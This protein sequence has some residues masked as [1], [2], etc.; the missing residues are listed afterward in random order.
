LNE[1][2]DWAKRQREKAIF[3]SEKIHLVDSV[4]QS[5]ELLKANAGQKNIVLENKVSLDI[6]VKADAFM[7]RSILQNLVTNAIKYTPMGGSVIITAHP[8]NKMVEVCIKDS[9][10]GMDEA[11]LKNLF[12]K[13][14]IISHNGTNNE[15]GSGLG[16]ILV[17]DF[18]TQHCG[19]IRAESEMGKGTSIIFT[20]PGY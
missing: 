2:V 6:Y 11:M 7:L 13:S 4:D 18:V 20:V 8:N 17:K 16:L 12:A 19:T 5:L 3:N 14:D 9:G 10:I 1:L 15:A